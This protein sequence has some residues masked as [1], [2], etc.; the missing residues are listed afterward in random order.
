MSSS[1]MSTARIVTDPLRAFN[2]R[3]MLI[4]SSSVAGVVSG[5]AGG[6]IGGFS[7]CTGLEATMQI[8]DYIEGGENSFVHKFPTRATYGNVTLRHGVG[9]GEDL[10]NWHSSFVQGKGKRRDALI[11]LGNE[12]QVPIKTWKLRRALPV[13]WVGPAFNAAQS[14]IAI[15]S[16]EMAHEG[17]EL[18]SPGTA[19]AAAVEAIF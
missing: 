7:E 9:L 19:A 3:I 2:F 18:Y 6:L 10:W 12:L 11:M 8:E 14:A 15:E 4:D 13:K 17:L 1:I 16:L 5:I